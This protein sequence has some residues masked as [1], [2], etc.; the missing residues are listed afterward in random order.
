M[1][2]EEN[3]DLNKVFIELAQAIEYFC[4]GERSAF[5]LSQTY[6]TRI[7][8]AKD[9]KSITMTTKRLPSV[10]IAIIELEMMNY[11]HKIY[12]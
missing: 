8:A 7:K 10:R 11:P 2:E 12:F 5:V 3:Q 6:S 1:T 9:V 4:H